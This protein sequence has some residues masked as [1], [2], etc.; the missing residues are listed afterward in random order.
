MKNFLS[1]C[2][3]LG[4]LIVLLF[5]IVPVAQSA[6]V[7]DFTA[8]PTTGTAPLTA[9]FTDASTGTPT[10]W[11]WFFGDENWTEAWTH[12]PDDRWSTRVGHT[13]VVM[14]DGSIVFMGGYD[15]HSLKNDVW[16]STDNGATWILV[17]ASAGWSARWRHSSVVMPD[18]SIV[19][20]G[21]Y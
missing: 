19:L 16:R 11:A 4:T 10:G 8:A 20:M 7:A 3:T 17:N 1:T 2:F 15:G 21:G 14:P 13:S 9:T 6:P 12:L 5:L 18:G